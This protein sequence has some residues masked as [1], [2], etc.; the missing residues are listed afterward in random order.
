MP[1][2][3][4]QQHWKYSVRILKIQLKSTITTCHGILYS[5]P[6][7]A[8]TNIWLIRRVPTMP[9]LFVFRIYPCIMYKFTF[10]GS[11]RWYSFQWVIEVITFFF[12]STEEADTNY[13]R[14]ID[15]CHIFIEYKISY[16]KITTQLPLNTT[17]GKHLDSFRAI[18]HKYWFLIFILLQ[19]FIQF[20]EI[21][22]FH[23][24]IHQIGCKHF[25]W[26]NW[27]IE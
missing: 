12:S 21:C 1:Y 25:R 3:F 16:L 17:V 20:L 11:D 9:H 7:F 6:G 27:T 15:D 18:I 19:A 13:L 4:P 24:H 14:N 2:S 10:F 23:T 26:L 8:C 22:A 5:I